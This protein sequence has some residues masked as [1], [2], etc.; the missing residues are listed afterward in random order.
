MWSW[1]P[2]NRDSGDMFLTKNS[3][4]N[5]YIDAIGL[6]TVPTFYSSVPTL[7]YKDGSKTRY[8]YNYPGKGP[9]DTG[10]LFSY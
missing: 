2:V 8:F 10:C 5:S 6:V 7:L 1:Q 4:S 9:A 3:I